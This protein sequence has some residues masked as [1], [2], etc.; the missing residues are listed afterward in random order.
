[1]ENKVILF[2]II[3]IISSF[4]STVSAG[5][6]LDAFDDEVRA[7]SVT[8]LQLAGDLAH[9]QQKV[10]ELEAKIV[11]AT[12]GLAGDLAHRKQK[13]EELE[14]KL[15]TA[16]SGSADGP[17]DTI[18]LEEQ[19]TR[20]RTLVEKEH[21][22]QLKLNALEKKLTHGRTLVKDEQEFQLKLNAEE[23]ELRKETAKLLSANQAYRNKFFWR[24]RVEIVGSES[25]KKMIF[26]GPVI[27]DVQDVWQYTLERKYPRGSGIKGLNDLRFRSFAILGAT[28]DL[29][30][31][32]FAGMILF[33]K[34]STMDKKAHSFLH[35]RPVG[36]NFTYKGNFEECRNKPL[37][38]IPPHTK[39]D[40][41]KGLPQLAYL[42]DK[43]NVLQIMDE[44]I[45]YEHISA[46]QFE[47]DV[48]H[49]VYNTGKLISIFHPVF[50]KQG[51]DLSGESRGA[52]ILYNF[53]MAQGR[54]DALLRQSGQGHLTLRDKV[55]RIILS[56]AT[57][58]IQFS[59]ADIIKYTP[60]HKDDPHVI[61]VEAEGDGVPGKDGDGYCTEIIPQ[62]YRARVARLG[63][64]AK[65]I[66]RT[67]PG[68]HGFPTIFVPLFHG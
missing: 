67:Y 63:V 39:S 20:A 46:Q 65:F 9:K 68:G 5:Y 53:M 19:L 60:Q 55:R 21:E 23:T 24:G 50:H 18:A 45:Q 47:R 52:F 51:I 40:I 33:A 13:V 58:P 14:A 7:Q 57:L 30:D 44:S 48:W 2:Q 17:V 36:I 34:V 42:T 35:R 29:F 61:W 3:L 32:P 64:K 43:Y 16:T 66:V 25:T 27:Q 54:Q 37:I 28:Y 8:T 62:N 41:N 1:M 56:T 31:N 15:A 4:I 10:E 38:I 26:G 11:T 22:S 59:D 6:F 12:S 49:N